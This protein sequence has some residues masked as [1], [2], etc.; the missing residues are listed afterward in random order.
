MDQAIRDFVSGK[1]IAVV[2]VSRTGK[3]FG[4]IVAT[5]LK[6][7]GYQV[8]AVH[9]EAK[10]IAGEPCYPNLASLAGKVDGAVICV[11][12]S[13][14][15]DV[16]RDAAAA[17]IQRIWLQQGAES[18]DVIAQARE[19]GLTTVAGK[20]LLMYAEPVRSLHGFHRGIMK[21]IGQY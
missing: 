20:C 19:L 14:A 1:R 3:K 8:F 2:G 7:R 4:N 6:Q 5:E 10:E 11:P 12:P 21:L 9:P 15:G 17:G 18:A 13:K 16:V